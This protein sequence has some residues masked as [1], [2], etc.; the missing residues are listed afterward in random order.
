MTWLAP[1]AARKNGN[2]RSSFHSALLLFVTR[3]LFLT[4]CL[5]AGKGSMCAINRS[6]IFFLLSIQIHLCDLVRSLYVKITVENQRKSQELIWKVLSVGITCL[7]MAIS[8]GGL[9]E[10]RDACHGSLMVSSFLMANACHQL[11][12]ARTVRQAR[13][14]TS[15]WRGM[16]FRAQ[17]GL[18]PFDP[19][20]PLAC[21]LCRRR[22]KFL[23]VSVLSVVR[24]SSMGTEWGGYHMQLRFE[25]LLYVLSVLLWC[26]SQYF[27]G[28]RSIPI[29]VCE[30]ALV[31]WDVAILY[32]QCLLFFL[33]RYVADVT[34][35]HEICC[36]RVHF[37][38]SSAFT[39]L[40][41]MVCDVPAASVLYISISCDEAFVYSFEFICSW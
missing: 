23:D 20:G 7:L 14:I 19:F 32:A 15:M 29:A 9:F 39:I 26:L 25:S 8:Y 18:V 16:H 21:A 24:F 10:F 40:F 35:R 3:V 11:N 36:E 33:C 4:S 37:I 27:H 28:R 13:T 5:S 2:A 22:F 30:K 34:S 12:V 31:W 1:N 41:C 17:W 38:W 6:S